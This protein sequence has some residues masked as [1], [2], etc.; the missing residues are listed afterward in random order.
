MRG[1]YHQG[2]LDILPTLPGDAYDYGTRSSGESHGV[3]LT[4]PHVVSLILDLAGYTPD[5]DLTELRLLEPSCGEGAFLVP[6]M[7]RLLTAA[8]RSGVNLADIPSPIVGLDIDPGHVAKARSAVAETLLRHGAEAGTAA[9]LADKW[10]Q[11]GDFLLQPESHRFDVIVGNPPYVRIEQLSVQLQREY[12]RRYRSLYDRADLYVAFI[13]RALQLLSPTGVLSFICADRWTVNRYGAPLREIVT[14]DFRVTC[15]VDLHTASPFESEVVAYPSIFAVTPGA[16]GP[17][18]VCG[19]STASPEECEAVLPALSSGVSSCPG[20]SVANYDSWFAG[21]EPWTITS[22][23]HLGALRSLESRF[24][25]IEDSGRTRVRI[26]VATGDD[27]TYIVG[28]NADIEPDRLVPLVMRSDIVQGRVRDARRFVINTFRDDGGV[29]DLRDYPRLARHLQAH[30]V[31]VRRRHVSQRNPASWFRTIDRVYPQ[32]VGTP[33]L[34]VPDIAG[35]NEV[36]FEEGRFHPHHNLYYVTSD[37][38]DMEVLGGLLSSRVA[39]F[40]V[41]SYAVK[42]RGG[43]LRFQAQYLRRIRLPAATEISAS[44]AASIRE[45]FRER[46]FPRLDEL[47]LEAY[48]I[49]DLPTFDFVDTRS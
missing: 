5:R 9:A 3:V 45:A 13:E 25:P 8:R 27:E 14:R 16:G 23:R 19:L 6:V 30:E 35:A 38:W 36:V 7:E 11:E 29:V 41:W 42:M 26:G 46:A 31:D 2:A 4:K 34:L 10:I 1:H 44:L 40:F 37:E 12:R 33:K 17:V 48:R 28:E 22:P 24:R 49:P 47:A 20:V 15:Y 21:T 32:L 39:L 18:Q 43:Y